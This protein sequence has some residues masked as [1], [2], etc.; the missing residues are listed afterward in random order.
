MESEM[1]SKVEV[2]AQKG[3]NALRRAVKKALA[4]QE[5]CAQKTNSDE[6]EVHP[7]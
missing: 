6:D 3:L 1:V 7:K 2:D 5:N 4:E